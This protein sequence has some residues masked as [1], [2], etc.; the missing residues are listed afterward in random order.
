MTSWRDERREAEGLALELPEGNPVRELPCV[1]G[2]EH[3]GGECAR[4]VTT[5]VYGL[6]FCEV[7]GAEARAGALEELYFDAGQEIQRPLNPHV[8]GLNPE[9]ERALEAAY[10]DLLE[11]EIV[12]DD[13][14]ETLLRAFPLIREHVCEHTLDY[15]EDPHSPEARAYNPPCD[16]YRHEPAAHP[17]ADEAG[18]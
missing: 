5:M 6:V 2:H 9:V 7:H 16:D 14:E 1:V 4:P 17:Q 3:A 15:V 13:V 11:R 18:L 8:Q 12:A 10:S